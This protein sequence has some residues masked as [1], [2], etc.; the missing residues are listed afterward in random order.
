MYE[1][2]LPIMTLQMCYNEIM[3]DHGFQGANTPASSIK[4]SKSKIQY[5]V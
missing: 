5:C 1:M 4:F 3:P 2:S